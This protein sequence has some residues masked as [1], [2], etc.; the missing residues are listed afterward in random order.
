M[1][2][3][4]DDLSFK[5]EKI[6]F[7]NWKEVFKLF[8]TNRKSIVFSLLALMVT[9]TAQTLF[10][11]VTA[12]FI[13]RFFKKG[14][15]DVINLYTIIFGVVLLLTFLGTSLFIYFAVRVEANINFN[16]RKKAFNKLQVLPYSYYDRTPAGWIMAR[17]SSD[18]NKVAVAIGEQFNNMIITFFT[19]LVAVG[20]MFYLNW[21]IALVFAICVP[22][23]SLV[24]FILKKAVFK[25]FQMVRRENSKVTAAYNEGI[26]GIA[27]TKSLVLEQHQIKSFGEQIS[28]LRHFGIKARLLSGFMWPI[29]VILGNVAASVILYFGGNDVMIGILSVSQ[30]TVVVNLVLR[31]I[32]MVSNFA[33]QISEIQQAQAAAERVIGLLK[34]E[35]EIKDTKEV[36]EKYGT[37]TE[38]KKENWEEINGDVE[39]KN[40]SFSYKEEERVLENFSLKVKKGEMIALVGATGGGKS[41]IVNLLCRF[42]EPT[43]GNIYIDGVDYKERSLGWLRQGI[44]Y[45]LQTP[46]LFK[47]TI[48]DNIL[49]GKLDATDEEI[50]KAAEDSQ[51]MAF[52]S[53]FPL[54]LDYNIGEAGAR[55]SLGERQLVSFARVLVKK[56][57]IVILDEATASVDTETE[58]Q[59]KKVTKTLLKGK[60]SFVVA[61]RL[62]T[63]VDADKIV[64][65]DNGKIV[66]MGTHRELLQ[67]RGRYF[68]LCVNELS[69]GQES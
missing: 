19:V 66:E 20:I 4:L 34:E 1:H 67:K 60:T 2:E 22:F 42:Y 55:L 31:T 38:P 21:K 47:G 27:T 23:L 63:I 40:V 10:P 5:K 54:G 39:F 56:P 24:V 62:S 46:H 8:L 64:V 37:L 13:D 3:H 35:V 53:K 45:V 11:F 57:S 25:A 44:G 16:L 12:E 28:S 26:I 51:V 65:I 30:L 14:Q 7:K 52:A 33:E 68:D 58:L 41:T 17:M 59:I 49:Y 69:K 6:K 50:I 15:Q 48:K 61:H 43:S 36:I 9:S 29:L 32:N 18:S